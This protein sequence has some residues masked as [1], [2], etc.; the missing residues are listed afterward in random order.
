MRD[1]GGANALDERLALAGISDE[2]VRRKARM[3][4]RASAALARRP[5]LRLWVPGRIEFLGKHTD[6]AGGRS[7]VCTVERGFVVVA[8][9]RNDRL[10][11]ITDV[12]SNEQVEIELSPSL[13]PVDGAWANYA[14][15]VVRRIARNFPGPLRGADIAFA[16]DLPPA[17]GLSSSSALVVATFLALSDLNA[18]S[19]HAEYRRAIASADDLAGYLGAVENGA[20]FRTLEG[21]RGVGTFS[22]SQDQTAILCSRAGGLVQ[23]SFA[24]VHFER[25]VPLPQDHVFVIGASG[26]LAEKTGG[27]LELYNRQAR[28][29]YGLLA[30]WRAATGRD[31]ATLAAVLAS[32]PDA[33]QRLRAIVRDPATSVGSDAF[34]VT[35]LV[36]R[37]DQFAAE[38]LEI[39]P[40]AGD[41]LERGDLRA[42][43]ELVDRSQ[44][45][46]EVLLGNQV[47]ETMHLA[48]SARSLGA[49]AASAF[50]AGFGGSV[51]ALVR[52]DDV[53]RFTACWKE[54]YLA[55]FPAHADRATF[56]VT[57]AGPA[58][59]TL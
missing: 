11:R 57:S 10:V 15:T 29:V 34:D 16:S 28:R 24:P 43:G 50:G 47:P 40:A 52:R 49:V 5:T 32:S 21:D 7:L 9:A 2:E 45:G 8:A 51:W 42:L 17:A 1:A 37:L 13:A 56:F 44:R 6:Y 22:G 36:T 14:I 55:R 30:R 58:A 3:F 35:D 12:V 53:E 18:L 38:A 33:L 25:T 4:A 27:A 46:A 23:Y 39:I 20:R 31:D 59:M 26:V 41:A 48:L 54:H 19:A